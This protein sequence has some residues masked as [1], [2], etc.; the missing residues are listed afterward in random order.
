M[1]L[2][3]QYIS[4]NFG[5]KKLRLLYFSGISTNIRD[6]SGRTPL[7]LA[8]FHGWCE[9]MNLLIENC[10]NVNARDNQVCKIKFFF[11]K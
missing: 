2:K 6:F 11:T 8:A 7:H 3:L 4:C 10:A 5:F 1:I 9:I